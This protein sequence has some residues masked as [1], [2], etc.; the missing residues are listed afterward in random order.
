MPSHHDPKSKSR[1]PFSALHIVGL[2]LFYSVLTFAVLAFTFFFVYTEGEFRLVTVLTLVIG[3]IAT[4]VHV[5]AGRRNR[6]D[7][8]IDH[9]P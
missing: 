5:K 9:G 7:T 3:L 1:Q 6:V 8:L 2:F 4:I